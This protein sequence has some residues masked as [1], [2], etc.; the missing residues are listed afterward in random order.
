[1]LRDVETTRVWSQDGRQVI[2][3]SFTCLK[4]HSPK[5]DSERHVFT[6]LGVD[7]VGRGGRGRR[8]GKYEQSIMACT[9]ENTTVNLLC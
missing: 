4:Y 8:R 1:M 9:D 3:Q 6:L 2:Y 7:G 5:P